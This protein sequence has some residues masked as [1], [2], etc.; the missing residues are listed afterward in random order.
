M[1]KGMKRA[2]TMRAMTHA[3]DA[4]RLDDAPTM[5]TMH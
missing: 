4:E 1:R 3:R 2:V 5:R